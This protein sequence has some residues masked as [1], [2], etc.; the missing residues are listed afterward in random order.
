MRWGLGSGTSA[1]SASKLW[2][3]SEHCEV[4]KSGQTLIYSECSQADVTFLTVLVKRLIHLNFYTTWSLFKIGYLWLMLFGKNSICFWRYIGERN[5]SEMYSAI[6]IYNLIY[7]WFLYEWVSSTGSL[8]TVGVFNRQSGLRER[9]GKREK[10]GEIGARGRGGK[11]EKR[12]EIGA[13]G[14]VMAK[15][16]SSGLMLEMTL[17]SSWVIWLNSLL[18]AAIL[19]FLGSCCS[20]LTV[21]SAVLLIDHIKD[22]RGS[23][24][25]FWRGTICWRSLLN[26]IFPLTLSWPDATI[27]WSVPLLV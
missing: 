9:G 8:G 15:V 19:F 27:L 21:H 25:T 14:R 5:K 11:R 7:L 10:R 6:F 22:P 24:I 1:L 20:S 13:R 26:R 12:G 17:K 23:L 4:K 18:T 16:C 3:G 2:H